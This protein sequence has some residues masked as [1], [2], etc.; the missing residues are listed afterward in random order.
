MVEL[1]IAL[2]ENFKGFRQ[3]V[4]NRDTNTMETARELVAVAVELR[5]RVLP[6]QDQL[7]TWQ[8]FFFMDVYRH[9]TAIVADRHGA[10]L[11]QG[12]PYF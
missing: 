9:A 2:D 3:R 4:D 5:A 10:I 1:A 11:A 7:N 8:L 12:D 6:G